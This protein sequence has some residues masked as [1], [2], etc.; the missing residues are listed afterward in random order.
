MIRVIAD[1]VLNHK[2]GADIVFLIKKRLQMKHV[3]M[4]CTLYAQT[5]WMMM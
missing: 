1:V 4:V 5:C 2:M 3:T